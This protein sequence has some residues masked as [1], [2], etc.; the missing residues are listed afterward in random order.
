MANGDPLRAKEIYEQIDARWWHYWMT[1]S[2]FRPQPERR[3]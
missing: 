1:W 3:T 2:S